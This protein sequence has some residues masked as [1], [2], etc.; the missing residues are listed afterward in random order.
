[1][2]NQG[3]QSGMERIEAVLFDWGGV[4]IDD[5][6]PG[7]MAYCAKAL[8][9][10]V[11]DYIAIHNRH[12]QPF[13]KGSIEERTFWRRVCGDLKRSTPIMGSLWGEAFRAVYA[14]RE[15]V[16]DLVRRLDETG[17]KTALLSNTETAAIEVFHERHDGLFNAL[18]FSCVEGACKPEQR[19]YQIAARKLQTPLQRC[20]LIDDRP[21]FVEGAIAAGMKAILYKDLAQTVEELQNLGINTNEKPG[22]RENDP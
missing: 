10:S 12:A 8:G 13:Q 2:Q 9:V 16:F 1:M 19:I 14:P 5:P 3:W 18:I 17:Y 11:E 15:P 7:L 6:A 20:V 4:L 22:V 21:L